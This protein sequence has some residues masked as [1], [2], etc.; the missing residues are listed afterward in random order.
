VASI[1]QH[2][3]FI[4][5]LALTRRM[6]ERQLTRQL[7]GQMRRRNRFQYYEPMQL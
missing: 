7:I 5:T 6:L 2:I 1:Q 3:D 4:S